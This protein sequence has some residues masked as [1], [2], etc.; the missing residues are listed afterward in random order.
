MTLYFWWGDFN[1]KLGAEFISGEI[2]QMLNNGARLN[3]VMEKYKFTWVKKK[4]PVEKSVLDYVITSQDLVL[5]VNSL[6]IDEAKEFTPWR[7]LKH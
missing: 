3:D 1:A 5:S 6:K 2:H 4:I 7:S